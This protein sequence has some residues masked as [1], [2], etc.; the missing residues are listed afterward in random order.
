MK[1]IAMT[2][3]E[4]MKELIELDPYIEVYVRGADGRSIHE[5]TF[6]APPPFSG[7]RLIV[8]EAKQ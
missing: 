7:Q 3:R 6:E 5:P 4:L 1:G 2:V 8:I